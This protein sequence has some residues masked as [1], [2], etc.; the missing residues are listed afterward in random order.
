MERRTRRGLLALWLL[1]FGLAAT[2]GPAEAQTGAGASGTGAA[3][4]NASAMGMYANPFANPYANPY[5]NPYANPLVNPM[6]SQTQMGAGNAAMYFL[7]AQKMNGGIGSGRLGG[8]NAASTATARA[9][10][11]GASTAQ[12]GGANV[13]GASAS[14]YFN[15][16]TPVSG[17]SA[18]YYGRQNPHYPNIGH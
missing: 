4:A 2:P 14:R 10:G 9:Q 1:G 18:R 16:S 3:N 7:A 6:A 5:I 11:K 17:G 12:P 15:R 13:P 8:P